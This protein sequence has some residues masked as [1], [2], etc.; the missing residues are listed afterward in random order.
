M[1]VSDLHLHFYGNTLRLLLLTLPWGRVL[2]IQ[3]K[4]KI[5]MIST[6]LDS[7][8]NFHPCTHAKEGRWM[9]ARRARG[10]GHIQYI[11]KAEEIH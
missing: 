4:A 5:E 8:N 1:K 6:R 9:G 11:N 2:H 10:V 3:K 7:S